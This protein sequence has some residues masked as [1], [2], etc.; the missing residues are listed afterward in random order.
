MTSSRRFVFSIGLVALVLGTSACGKWFNCLTG[1]DCDS[2]NAI[3]NAA[4]KDLFLSVVRNSLSSLGSVLVELGLSGTQKDTVITNVQTKAQ[5]QTS[6]LGLATEATYS[7]TMLENLSAMFQDLMNFTITTVTEVAP[8]VDKTSI[9]NV[10]ANFMNELIAN[11]GLVGILESLPVDEQTTLAKDPE[12]GKLDWEVFRAPLERVTVAAFSDTVSPE[13]VG[14]AV[15]RFKHRPGESKRPAQEI[16][17]YRPNK[18]EI[19]SGK[20]RIQ[21]LCSANRGD[22][23]VGNGEVSA[24]DNDHGIP[25]PGK[26]CRGVRIDKKASFCLFAPETSAKFCSKTIYGLDAIKANATAITIWIEG[27]EQS[28]NGFDDGK[29]YDCTV[30]ED[31]T[32]LAQQLSAA[33]EAKKPEC[34]SALTARGAGH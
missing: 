10:C 19:E 16:I 29:L 21:G 34:K 4:T 5:T 26:A 15:G 27:V 31:R 12:T 14:A 30:I 17:G 9:M 20:D 1:K 8:Q 24:A 33:I 13:T 6:Q 23:G 2:I 22:V 25:V 7:G 11:A 32:K 28:F 3:E 18:D